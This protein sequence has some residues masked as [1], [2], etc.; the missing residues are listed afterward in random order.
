MERLVGIAQQWYD[1]IADGEIPSIRLPTRT[2][3]NIAYDEATDVWKYGEKEST[4]SASTARSAIHLLK[5]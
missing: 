2:K 4:R 3:Q 5:M 1:Q